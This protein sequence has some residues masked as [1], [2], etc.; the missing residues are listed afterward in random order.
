MNQPKHSVLCVDDNQDNLE[1]ITFVFEHAGFDVTACDTLND[2]LLH[3]RSKSLD[4]IILDNRFGDQ[5]SVEVCEEIRS[6]NPAIPI[7]FYSGEARQFEIE[8]ALNECGNAYLVKPND[9]EKLIPTVVNL[10]Q[11]TDKTEQAA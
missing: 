6:F 5:S 11:S 2:C 4:A 8:R 1:L 3:A 9:F 10:I 7:V